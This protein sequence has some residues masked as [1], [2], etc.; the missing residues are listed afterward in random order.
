[1]ADADVITGLVEGFCGFM[2]EGVLNLDYN[3]KILEKAATLLVTLDTTSIRQSWRA[4]KFL[5]DISTNRVVKRL[6]GPTIAYRIERRNSFWAGGKFYDVI[7][8]PRYIEKIQRH[9]T[10]CRVGI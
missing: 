7:I 10:Q 5:V 4:Q 8:H 9:I 3:L 6:L 2:E 1:M